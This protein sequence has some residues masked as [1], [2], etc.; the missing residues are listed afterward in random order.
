MCVNEAIRVVP[1]VPSDAVLASVV[2]TCVIR[3]GHP[4]SQ[5][6]LSGINVTTDTIDTNDHADHRHASEKRFH[7]RL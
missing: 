3:S 7:A 2:V 4:A 1:E 5:V 6:S